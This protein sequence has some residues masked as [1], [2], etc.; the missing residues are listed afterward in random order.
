MAGDGTGGTAMRLDR[1]IGAVGGLY[2][3]A[4]VGLSAAAAHAVPGSSL[5]PA[6]AMLLVHGAALLALSRA[7]TAVDGGRRA[8]ALVM[9]A[10]AALFSGDLTLRTFTG[11][12]LFPMAAPTGGVAMIAAWLIAALAYAVGRRDPAA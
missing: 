2:G 5:G 4:G 7:G 3:A 6:G 12:H 1:M 11:A 8:A 9:I 10:G